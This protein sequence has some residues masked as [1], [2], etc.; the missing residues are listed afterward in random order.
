MGASDETRDSGDGKSMPPANAGAAKTTSF[1]A[2]IRKLLPPIG[3]TLLASVLNLPIYVAVLPYLLV[4]SRFIKSEPGETSLQ[5]W[6]KFAILQFFFSGL[7]LMAAVGVLSP[8]FGFTITGYHALALFIPMVTISLHDRTQQYGLLGTLVVQNFF[9]VPLLAAAYV[10]REFFGLRLMAPFC[11]ILDDTIVQG[12][13]PFPSDIATLA[14]EPYNV[15]LIVN[16]CR[17]YKG[18]THQ[19]KEHGIVQCYQPHQDTTAVSYDS[20]VAGCQYIRQFRKHNPN[21]RVYV[22]CKGGIARASTM[23]LAH[24]VQNEGK[25]PSVAIREMKAKRHVVFSGVKDYP[26]IVRLNEERLSKQSKPKAS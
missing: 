12:S 13:L 14:A 20:L 16:M 18:A 8:I 9:D 22:H 17:E 5:W 7:V 6:T 1:S 21:K 3:A 10:A 11:N 19:M 25:D 23:V 4:N 26:A 24:Y 2:S 15:G